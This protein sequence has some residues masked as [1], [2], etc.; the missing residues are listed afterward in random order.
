M[1][2]TCLLVFLLALATLAF[3]QG[4]VTDSVKHTGPK[5]A[6]VSAKKPERLNPYL[7]GELLSP[8]PLDR[9]LFHDKIDNEQKRADAADGKT[10]G[11]I[12]LFGSDTI[13]AI[14]TNALIKQ[15]DRLQV[16]VEN[17]PAVNKDTVAE[18]QL[19]IQAL[20]GLWELLR[21]YS[22]DLRPRPSFYDSLVWNMGHL[23]VAMNENKGYDFVTAH[24]TIYTLDNGKVILGNSPD[25]RAYIYLAMAQD[26]PVL[27]A[28]RLEE[29]AK[30]TFAHTIIAGAA[31]LDPNL[32][33]NYA[34]SSN[35]LLK[36][37]VYGTHD[38]FVQAI[39]RASAE[40][41]APLRALPFISY[42][43]TNQKTIDEIDTI[44]ADPAKSFNAL[45]EMRISNEPLSRSV[46][47]AELEYRTLKYFVRQMNELHDTTDD[48][49]FQC[50]DSLP[51][52][53][54]FYIMVYGR[55]EIYTSSFIGTFRRMVERM[56]PL[57]GNQFLDSLHHDHFRTFIRLCAGYNTLTD[58]L[59]TMD[60]TART[61]LMSR[62]IAGLDKGDEN[63]LEDAVN[64]ADALGSITDSVLLIFLQ[65]EIGRNYRQSQIHESKKGMA[66]YSLLSMLMESNAKS[67]SDA[68]ALSAS[69]KLK[70]PP[71]NIVPHFTLTDDTGTI[72]ERV[73]FYG[74]ED[75][76]N[77]YNGYMEDYRKN[78][79]WK[80][81]TNKYWATI[82]STTGKRVI[83]YAN[84][85]LKTPDDEKAID[86]LDQYLFANNIQPSIVIH[87]G[88]SYHVKSTLE[89]LDT[90]ARIVVLGSCG[91]YQNVAKVLQASANAHIISSK[92]TGV[93]AIN[94][95]ITRAINASLQEGQDINWIPLW[96]GLDDY[97]L[98]RT[99]LYTR[100]KDYV[101]P[102]K[103]LGVIFIKAY[104]QLMASGK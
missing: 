10:D 92:Q 8:I 9:T 6:N 15:I 51:A 64:V 83:M 75:G 34:L 1:R 45:A 5:G 91:G 39:V 31:R 101:P 27:L 20:R 58:F 87:R 33:F 61:S 99:D 50:I 96:T 74:D 97:F 42:I 57:K 66:I 23:I 46:Y 19:K 95:P 52:T 22:V 62:F 90:N 70:I 41:D 56:P 59:A 53:S 98:K 76:Q 104:R 25:A 7:A 54:L 100:F 82:T 67:N 86:S 85:P 84:M 2:I 21:Q 65:R 102:H 49:R 55:E 17:L 60:D 69:G 18:N 30:D 35:M 37:A 81:D 14:Y 43:Y 32:I 24:P 16:L 48:V 26:D 47:T 77:A 28:R 40:S 36:T 63:D 4:P 3:G 44:A 29:F 89:R 79:L 93:G 94:E 103:N 13:T 80:V 72:H 78:K 38:P 12:A 11:R 71:I 88:H 68:G 73:F